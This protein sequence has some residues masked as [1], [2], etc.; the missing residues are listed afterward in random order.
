MI[1]YI[2]YIIPLHGIMIIHKNQYKYKYTTGFNRNEFLQLYNFTLNMSSGSRYVPSIPKYTMRMFI[3]KHPEQTAEKYAELVNQYI[4][5]V[6]AHNKKQCETEYPDSGFDLSVPYNYSNYAFGYT[7]N[8]ISPTTFRAPL[9]VKCAMTE[10]VSTNRIASEKPVSYYLYPRSSIVKT[11]FR[12]AN[13]VGIIDAGYRGEIMAVV[14]NIDNARNDMKT[15]LDRYAPPMSRLFQ[16]CSPT[17]EPFLVKIVESENDLGVTERGT[18][19]FGST[20]V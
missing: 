6:S 14:D 17:L 16:I 3:M 12:M 10:T 1:L 19:G 8:C 5:K 18:G 20:G 9:S 2:L 13:S 7:D 11:P 4:E 15:C